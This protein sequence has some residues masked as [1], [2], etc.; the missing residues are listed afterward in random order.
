MNTA[1]SYL[2]NVSANANEIDIRRV[3]ER[4]RE[5]AIR[6]RTSTAQERIAKIKRL[7]DAVMAHRTAIH[8]AAY[9]DF[10]KPPAEVDLAELIRQSTGSVASDTVRGVRMQGISG[11]EAVGR[12]VGRLR[13]MYP[14]PRAI[15][16]A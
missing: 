14:D 1:V 11:D 15:A 6:L 3:F 2:P 9:K 12:A 5:T 8:E 10:E 13:V 7:H 4:Q 16:A